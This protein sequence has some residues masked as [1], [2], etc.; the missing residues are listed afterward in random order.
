MEKAK[1]IAHVKDMYA[2]MLFRED[3]E[4]LETLIPELK[5]SEDERI[6]KYLIEELKAAKS[7]GE[8][9]FTIP[10]PTRE[11]CIAYLEKQKEASKAIEAVDRIDKYIDEHLANAHDMK[12]SNPDKKYYRGWDDALGKTA[13]IL[14]DVYSGEKQKEQKPVVTHGETYRVDTLGTQQVIAGKMPQKPAEWDEKDEKVYDYLKSGFEYASNNPNLLNSVLSGA[15]DATI[16]D[17]R[18]FIDKLKILRPQPKQE[19]SEED[20]RMLSR[21]I[22][23]VESSKNFAEVQ[24]FKEAKDK[25]KDWLKTLPERFNPQPKQEWSEEDETIRHGIECLIMFALQD[26]SSIAPGC[27]TT[28]E[29][30]LNWLKSL[31][32]QPKAEWNKEDEENMELVIDCIYNFYPD[33]VMKYKLKDWLK[34]LRPVSKESLQPHWKPSKD[35]EC[36]NS[37]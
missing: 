13:G 34:S 14:Q 27:A 25:E 7:I 15:S 11:E 19:W 21:C 3:K 22:K 24:T 28:K 9:K 26:G 36:K 6:R 10:Q 17:Y 30:A 16:Q 20:K 35:E 4:A 31:R 29:Q 5:E 8:L 18:N 2:H 1:A 23:S 12:D 32:P 33:P 37:K